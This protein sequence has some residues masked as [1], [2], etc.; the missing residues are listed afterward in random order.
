MKSQGKDVQKSCPDALAQYIKENYEQGNIVIKE[1]KPKVKQIQKSPE[2]MVC[3]SCG[4]KMRLEAGC[5]VCTCGFS[6]CG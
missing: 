2:K 1:T 3:P 6:K 5:I 4:E